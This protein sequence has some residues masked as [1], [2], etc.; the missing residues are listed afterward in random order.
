[1]ERGKG[2]EL[3]VRRRSDLDT[4]G[5]GPILGRAEDELMLKAA[6]QL[7]LSARAYHRMLKVARTIADLDGEERI[8]RVHVAEALT[9]RYRTVGATKAGARI[10]V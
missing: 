5:P 2:V 8:A 6:E 7:R 1:M 4:P 3:E 9:Y 10:N